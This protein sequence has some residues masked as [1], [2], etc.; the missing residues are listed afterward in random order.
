MYKKEFLINVAIEKL[1]LRL[2]N[3]LKTNLST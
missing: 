3:I 1:E 2:E